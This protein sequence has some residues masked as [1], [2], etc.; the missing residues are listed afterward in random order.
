VGLFTKT[1]VKVSRLNTIG[2][3]AASIMIRTEDEINRSVGE[4]QS[5]PRF[6]T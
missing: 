4:S 1:R 5:L 2:R 6:L 3:A